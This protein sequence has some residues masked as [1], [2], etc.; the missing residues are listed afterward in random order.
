MTAPQVR[1]ITPT[2]HMLCNGCAENPA[3]YEVQFRTVLVCLCDQCAHVLSVQVRDSRA[4]E[5]QGAK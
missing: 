1:P 2:N 3:Q 5:Q 4:R